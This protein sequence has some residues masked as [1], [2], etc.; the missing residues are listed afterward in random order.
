MLRI[1]AIF[2]GRARRKRSARASGLL[3]VVAVAA[4][5][6]HQFGALALAHPAERLQVSDAAVGEDPAGFD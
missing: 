1:S 2:A 3:L 6:V 5:A 4:E